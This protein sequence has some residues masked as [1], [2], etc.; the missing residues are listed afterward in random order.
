MRLALLILVFSLPAFAAPP[1]DGPEPKDVA[2][3][4]SHNRVPDDPYMIY[5][6]WRE[7]GLP[8]GEIC[9]YRNVRVAL[10]PDRSPKPA[11]LWF[12]PYSFS[13]RC[14]PA[15]GETRTYRVRAC[16]TNL[17]GCSLDWSNPVTVIG[18]PAAEM[19]CCTPAGCGEC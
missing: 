5:Y 13:G 11:E 10:R 7:D 17:T 3:R 8:P 18:V 19:R 15:S 6:D 4:I 9:G 2:C 14:F 12:N 16:W 1:C